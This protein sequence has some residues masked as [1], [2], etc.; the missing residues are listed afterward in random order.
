MIVKADVQGSL[1][2]VID[3][4][5][6]IDTEG[7]VNLRIVG[8][9]VGNISENDIH[10]AATEG[11]VVYGFSVELPPAVKRQAARDKVEVRIYQ[12]DL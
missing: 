5:R 8:S 7:K 11:T 2:S 12:R 1:T 4:L 10:L 9:G 6:L 3:S